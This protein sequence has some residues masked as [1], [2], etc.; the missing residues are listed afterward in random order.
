MPHSSEVLE[1]W[2]RGTMES[3]HE[4]ISS[5]SSRSGLVLTRSWVILGKFK[6]FVGLGN[7]S[8]GQL[9]SAVF[10]LLQSQWFKRSY[11]PLPHLC[12]TPHL[13]PSGYYGLLELPTH[14]STTP[15]SPQTLRL[16][17]P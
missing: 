16:P 4:E 15:E 17:S 6:D 7:E 9:F 12:P 3:F 5:V 14:Q 8:S 10:K 1:W 11:R 13:L 2:Q